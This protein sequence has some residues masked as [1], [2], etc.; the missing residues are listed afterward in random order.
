MN[1]IYAEFF[2]KAHMENL[3]KNEKF[4]EDFIDVIVDE[5]LDKLEDFLNEL[6]LYYNKNDTS[7]I[8]K[9]GYF[10]YYFD[11]NYDEDYLKY[12]ISK[13]GDLLKKVPINFYYINGQPNNKFSFTCNPNELLYFCYLIDLKEFYTEDR[14]E[15]TTLNPK[16]KILNSKSTESI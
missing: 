4:G 16:T 12:A 5:F 8:N 3:E 15:S 7:N 10:S 9:K 6:M 13:M 11:L 2:K 1:S 14:E